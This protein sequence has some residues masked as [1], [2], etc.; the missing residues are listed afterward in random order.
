MKF[1][2]NTEYCDRC[3]HVIER[4]EFMHQTRTHTYCDACY[5]SI[6]ARS[7]VKLLRTHSYF[8]ARLLISDHFV[9]TAPVP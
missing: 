9:H 4:R 2:L 5:R 8:D 1:M 6:F 7:M 3:G